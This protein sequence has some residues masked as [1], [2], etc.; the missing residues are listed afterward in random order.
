MAKTRPEN[1][2]DLKKLSAQR[3]EP[4]LK[5]AYEGGKIVASRL[6]KKVSDTAGNVASAAEREWGEDTRAAKRALSGA[7]YMLGGDEPDK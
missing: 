2:R 6:A 4:F 1:K 3:K 5:S 7:K